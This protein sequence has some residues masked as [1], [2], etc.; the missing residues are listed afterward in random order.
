MYPFI[1]IPKII[2]QIW[3]Q[4]SE[5]IPDKYK[6]NI[7]S[8]KKY[9]PNYKYIIWDEIKIL[10]LVKTNNNWIDIYYKFIYIHQK[11]DFA[12]YIILQKFGG[13][14]IDI[15]V[16]IIKSFDS[17]I[18]QY[19]NYDVIISELTINEFES[20]IATGTSKG[21]NNGIILSKKDSIVMKNLIDIIIKEYNPSSFLPKVFLINN[22]TGPNIFTRVMNDNLQYIKILEAEYLE[23]CLRDDCN[24]TDNTI[25]IHKHNLTWMPDEFKNVIDLYLKNKIIFWIII[26]LICYAIYRKLNK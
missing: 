2:H 13:I 4:G 17:L 14:Y 18:K 7:D 12:K 25:A 26:L 3:L 20:F 21:Y 9:H 22:S 15:D 10:E 5:F 6:K 8:V 1:M 11:I 23:P 19:D 24:I 16:E